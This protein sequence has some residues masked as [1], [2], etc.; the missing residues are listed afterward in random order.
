MAGIEWTSRTSAADNEWRSVIYGNGL[1]VAV[2]ATGT[3]NRV[4]TSPDGITWT[5]QTSAADNQWRSVTYGEPNGNG[6]F[7]AVS[8][9]GTGNRVMTSPDGITWTSRTSIAD[10][11]WLSITYGEPNGNGLFVAVSSSGNANRVMTSPDGIIWTSR[12]SAAN[13]EWRSVTYG[14]PNGNSLFVAVSFS[15]T[16]NRVMT[17]P[18]GITWTSRTSATDNLWNSVTFG[19]DLF[20]AV[21]VSGTGNRVMT[22]PDGIT[23]TSRSSATNNSWLSVTYENDIFVAVASSGT[24]NRVMTSGVLVCVLSSTKILMKDCTLKEIKDIVK[25]DEILEDIKTGK[26][27]IVSRIISSRITN[28][29]IIKIPK[30]LLD[31]E[32]DLFLSDLH[33]IW[34]NNDKNRTYAK[35]IKGCENFYIE[36]DMLYNIQYDTEGT[37]Y[38]N[39]IKVDSLSPYH[40]YYPLPKELFINENIYKKGI[41]VK[42]E[43]DK[44]RNKPKMIKK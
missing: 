29:N 17:S 16:G 36:E 35:D 19:K 30:K 40:K 11:S 12:T 2:S 13:N 24:G 3:G 26:T 10:N 6:L 8:S 15:G 38:A 23:W 7:V 33:P 39:G 32:E 4:M 31:N 37:F 27:N 18:D 44:I 41:K 25:G 1:F 5:L 9:S 42:T 22:S 21:A 43:D 34:V 20:V 14:E 28:K